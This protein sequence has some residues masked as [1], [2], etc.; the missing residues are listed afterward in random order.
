MKGN[1]E[2]PSAWFS[3]V[4]PRCKGRKLAGGPKGEGGRCG[5]RAV[6]EE[7]GETKWTD[8]DSD[9]MASM[10]P[11]GLIHGT[12]CGSGEGTPKK[13][14]EP[15]ISRRANVANQEE[16]FGQIPIPLAAGVRMHFKKLPPRDLLVFKHPQS[17]GHTK[18]EISGV[19]DHMGAIGASFCHWLQIDTDCEF[20]MCLG[21]IGRGNRAVRL[22]QVI[23][24]LLVGVC[25][26]DLCPT[27]LL[28]PCQD[29]HMEK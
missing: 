22:V 9:D 23:C 21:F 13:L 26:T 15:A 12:A 6:C 24:T 20:D 25:M 28:T 5:E 27:D 2:L 3:S 7:L 19:P 16:W 1:R 17:R 29:G 14:S 4:R 11:Q 8:A 10:S 18:Q